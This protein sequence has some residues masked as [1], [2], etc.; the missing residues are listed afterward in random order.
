MPVAADKAEVKKEERIINPSD[1]GA[2]KV[3]F[4]CYPIPE[5]LQEHRFMIFPTLSVRHVQVLPSKLKIF[6]VLAFKSH[7]L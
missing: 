6:Q 4:P 7:E 3:I 5:V 1:S 2:S